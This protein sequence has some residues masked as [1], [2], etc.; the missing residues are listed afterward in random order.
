MIEFEGEERKGQFLAVWEGD[1]G[2]AWRPM[3]EEMSDMHKL[4]GAVILS[5]ATLWLS[6][7]VEQDV[8]IPKIVRL[9]RSIGYVGG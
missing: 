9:V 4:F 5:V 1:F 7:E 2:R 8:L 6:G 3:E